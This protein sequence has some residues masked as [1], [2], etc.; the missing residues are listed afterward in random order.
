MTNSPH[1]AHG[2][3][4]RLRPSVPEL[5]LLVGIVAMALYPTVSHCQSP[6]AT[7]AAT[8]GPATPV[9]ASAPAFPAQATGTP[10]TL[11]EAIF[12]LPRLVADSGE[13]VQPRPRRKRTAACAARRYARE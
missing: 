7:P 2:R 4:M 9:S 8:A 6:A 12:D 13:V 11:D 1:S 10:I 5:S 3:K